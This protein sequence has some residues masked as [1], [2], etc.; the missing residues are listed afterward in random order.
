MQGPGSLSTDKKV[1][2]PNIGH[3]RPSQFNAG[4]AQPTNKGTLKLTL[5]FMMFRI[6]QPKTCVIIGII[7]SITGANWPEN[8]AIVP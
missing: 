6:R 4:A 8:F 2:Q 1:N 3:Q 7:T 5:R